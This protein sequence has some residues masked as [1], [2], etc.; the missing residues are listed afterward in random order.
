MGKQ[1]SEWFEDIIDDFK[2]TKILQVA[3]DAE[4][5]YVELET[6]EYIY[7][8]KDTREAIT[9]MRVITHD[10]IEPEIFRKYQKKD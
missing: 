4:K 8:K 9:R 5:G 6:G 1:K 2:G 7:T 10:I 3:W